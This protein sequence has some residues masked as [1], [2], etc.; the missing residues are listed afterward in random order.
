MI[1]TDQIINVTPAVIGYLHGG[2]GK[3]AVHVL[4]ARHGRERTRRTAYWDRWSRG[5]PGRHPSPLGT[6]EGSG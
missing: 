5:S 3:V 4:H 6:S 2:V 1:H